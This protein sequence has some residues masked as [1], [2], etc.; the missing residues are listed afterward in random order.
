MRGLI[1]ATRGTI[2]A[3]RFA[4][5][6]LLGA[7]GVAPVVALEP[8]SGEAPAIL[9][10]ERRLCTMLQQRDA[11]GDDLKCDLSKTWV[12][13]VIK[14]ADQPALKWGFGDARCSIGIHIARA[15]IAA[16][17]NARGKAYKLWITPHTAT[18]QVE[19]DGEVQTIKATLAPKLLLKDGRVEKIWVNL[20]HLD[21]PTAIKA[22]LWT[23]AKLTDDVGLFQRPLIKSVNRFISTTCPKK[24]PLAAASAEKGK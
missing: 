18:C 12:R 1:P 20:T 7:A 4:A 17:L 9:D 3:A 19:L 10:C 16:A 24:Y 22:T 11:K 14:Q 6:M 8:Q 13:N 21:G 23:A 5:A 2:G 15:E